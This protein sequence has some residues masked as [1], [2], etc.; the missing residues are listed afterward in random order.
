MKK[1]YS[2]AELEFVLLGAEDILT[3]S[4]ADTENQLP[5]D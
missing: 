5:I 4:E 1:H 3:A 2:K